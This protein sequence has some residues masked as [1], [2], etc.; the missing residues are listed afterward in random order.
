MHNAASIIWSFSIFYSSLAFCSG[1]ND[2]TAINKKRLNTVIIGTG[3]AYGASLVA[4]NEAWY[5][6]QQSTFHFF[7]DN[8]QWNQVDKAGHMYSAYQLSKAGKEL[9]LWTNMSDKK[10]GNLGQCPEPDF[11]DT[12]RGI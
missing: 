8:S 10:V 7:N 9:F 3:V 4:L 1:N 11:H 5:K 2:S 6:K 12:D